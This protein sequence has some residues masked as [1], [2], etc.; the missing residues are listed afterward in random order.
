LIHSQDYKGIKMPVFYGSRMMLP[1]SAGNPPF[2]TSGEAK[3]FGSR[4]SLMQRFATSVYN[5][6]KAHL[7]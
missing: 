2:G 4:R 6:A 5:L 7:W 1:P 3:I